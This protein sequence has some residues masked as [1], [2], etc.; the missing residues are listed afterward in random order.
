MCTFS[1]TNDVH[2]LLSPF[3]RV[4]ALVVCSLNKVTHPH[5]SYRG[6][7]IFVQFYL[8]LLRTTHSSHEL[9]SRVHRGPL[10]VLGHGS[11]SA[12]RWSLLWLK[13]CAVKYILLL[14]ARLFHWSLPFALVC[15]CACV[16]VT[17][18]MCIVI[19]VYVS[20]SLS[21]S[22]PVYVGPIHPILALEFCWQMESIAL[23]SSFSYS[24][25][26]SGSQV[27]LLFT[28]ASLLPRE[29]NLYSADD[30]NWHMCVCPFTIACASRT[31]RCTFCLYLPVFPHDPLCPD[32]FGL[33]WRKLSYSLCLHPHFDALFSFILFVHLTQVCNL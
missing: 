8:S 17:D 28:I 25:L 3:L 23:V 26:P 16:F 9:G 7:G 20:L 19:F 4:D 18:C 22:L 29:F 15:P 31:S 12:D 32:T 33:S 27:Y 13:E 6:T 21:L 11:P 24:F 5:A 1:V 2:T 14:I 10:A 30:N